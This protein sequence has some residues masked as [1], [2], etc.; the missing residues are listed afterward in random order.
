M[1]VVEPAAAALTLKLASTD[2]VFHPPS[3]V[4]QDA[5]LGKL[6]LMVC[7]LE[8]AAPRVLKVKRV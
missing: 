1:G 4:R 6:V 8:V 7:A 2:S 5:L 3:H